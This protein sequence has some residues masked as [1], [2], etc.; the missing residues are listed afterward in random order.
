[1]TE[2][3]TKFLDE[4][5]AN[6]RRTK[7]VFRYRLCRRTQE[8]IKSINESHSDDIKSIL[9]VGAADGLMLFALMKKYPQA[10]CVGIEYSQD[11]VRIA[12]R[13]VGIEVFQADAQ[14]LPFKKETFDIVI[15]TAII[16]HLIH[17]QG[18]ILESFRVLRKDGVL[19][20]TS[21]VPF[22]EDIAVM[23]GH[24]KGNQH[25]RT[26]NI[27]KLNEIISNGGFKILKGQKFMLFGLGMPFEFSME[28]IFKNLKLDLFFVNQVIIGRKV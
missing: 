13:D 4:E 23:I 22:W 24:L 15:A 16:E 2:L 21:P 27:R 9:D 26:M 5:Y 8:V 11:L 7:G 1:M 25:Y 28:R 3:I 12:R 20:L 10:R 19:I 17:P 14:N 18:M 6:R